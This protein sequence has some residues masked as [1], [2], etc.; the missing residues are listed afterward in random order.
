MSGICGGECRWVAA[1][2]VVANDVVDNHAVVL[3]HNKLCAVGD[4]PEDGLV[5]WRRAGEVCADGLVWGAEDAAG[6][7]AECEHEPEL[8]RVGG[9]AAPVVVCLGWLQGTVDAAAKAPD[10]RVLL[11]E[12]KGVDGVDVCSGGA[13]E[14]AHLH[15]CVNVEACHALPQVLFLLP[16]ILCHE[17]LAGSG[18]AGGVLGV[19]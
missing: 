14:R 13:V 2:V 8:A 5:P 19:L 11:A 7:H 10:A 16:V 3:V 9:A 17:L 18:G 1:E 4:V 12:A 15:V 6:E